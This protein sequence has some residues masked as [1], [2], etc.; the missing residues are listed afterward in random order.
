MERTTGTPFRRVAAGIA[1]VAMLAACGPGGTAGAS[2]GIAHLGKVSVDGTA[3]PDPTDPLT[4]ATQQL[5]M[6]DYAG[7]T[8][9]LKNVADPRAARLRRTIA[10]AQR[11]TTAYPDDMSI[12]HLFYHSLIVDPK[13]AFH[14]GYKVRGYLDYMV[15]EQEFKG[16]LAQM[17][18]KGYVLV[19]PERIAAQ[20]A[21][22]EMVTKPIMLPPGKKPLVLSIDDVSYYDYMVGDG[23]AT[24]L[25]VDPS[26]KV[27][28][29]YIDAQGVKHIG[30]YD[31]STVVDDF[32]GEHP[33][34]SYQGDKGTIALT[35]Y[36]G[37]LGYHSSYLAYGHNP[38]T[39]QARKSATAVAAAMKT[40]GWNFA[41]HSYG[42]INF[43]KSP[44]S[45]IKLD[46][47]RWKADVEPIIG[48]TKELIYP[49]GADISAVKK[50]GPDNEKYRYLY[51]QGFR[52]FANVD[53]SKPAW[54][55]NNGQ[56]LR[57][58]RIDVDGITIDAA[59]AGKRTPLPDFFD[60]SAT[61]DP[62]RLAAERVLSKKD[63]SKEG[64]DKAPA[65]GADQG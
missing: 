10:T 27:R 58:A 31:V 40:S 26:G 13:R 48:P 2:R 60:V 59:L 61:V 56:T 19:H 63:S 28:N 23:F 29:T 18:A 57:Q 11:A 49:F 37:V 24:N 5:A 30:A 53:W 25:M 7:A 65:K 9:T 33:D 55:Q 21:S 64:G 35:G 15:T 51:D 6:Y 43:T 42:H 32:V 4:V 8:A 12:S 22:G 17:Y 47:E 62:E 39:D 46:N 52:Y 20:N 34:F 45:K 16:Q 14:S 38:A 50:Y 41:S 3:R 54:M 44:L 1:A 36:N